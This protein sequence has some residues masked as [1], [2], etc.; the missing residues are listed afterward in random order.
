MELDRR[1]HDVDVIERVLG[2]VHESREPDDRVRVVDLAASPGQST[3][4]VVELTLRF[5]D[6]P[7]SRRPR[8]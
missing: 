4:A 3:G 2:S 8:D 1:K 7:P 6:V 5:E